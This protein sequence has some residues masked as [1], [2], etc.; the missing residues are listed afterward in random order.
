MNVI[1]KI[2]ISYFPYESEE[3][4]KEILLKL[5]VFRMVVL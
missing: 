2:K 4:E 1:S 3:V 5:I